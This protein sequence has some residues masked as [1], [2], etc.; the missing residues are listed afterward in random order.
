MGKSS[1]F[2]V[3]ACAALLLAAPPLGCAG[4][5]GLTGPFLVHP[6][7]PTAE[8]YSLAQGA[9]VFTGPEFTVSARPWDWRLVEKEF[10]DA[11]E[12]NPFGSKPGDT[13]RFLF[14][15]VR[16]ENRST[17]PLVFNPLRSSVLREG[18]APLLPLEN[19]D[20]F[21]FSG[22]EKG[23]E[24]LARVFRRVSFDGTA[25]V[26][27]G[28]SEERYLVFRSPAEAKLLSLELDEVWVGSASFTLRFPFE[29]FPGK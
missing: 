22:G 5:R 25:T 21:A 6:V 13:G 11:C 10:R 7:P 24:A 4:H 9:L 2:A 8:G 3:A 27:A 16:L 26:K 15:R 23:V 17:Q 1:R 18:E 14:F 28:G 29:A 19:S 20:L 12:N